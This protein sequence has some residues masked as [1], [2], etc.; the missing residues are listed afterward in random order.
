MLYRRAR[1]VAAVADSFVDILERRGIPRRKTFVV[2]NGVDLQRFRP[3][4]DGSEIK[5]QFSLEG[6]FIVMYIG[7]IGMAHALEVAL[8]AAR[9]TRQD[10]SIVYML[11]GTGARHDELENRAKELGLSNVVFA[12]RRPR[13]EVPEFLAAADAVLV[14]L[15]AAELFGNVIP[16]K[17]FEIMGCAKPIIMGVRGE[18]LRIVQDAGAALAMK[19]ESADDLVAAVRQLRDTPSLA[20]RLGRSGRAYVEAN[21]DRDKLAEDYIRLL[22]RAVLS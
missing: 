14:H 7:T 20:E 22:E 21:F 10:N 12:G 9:R 13:E 6:K 19:P 16:S 11:V 15:K 18:A 2:K 5:A 3:D 4:I 17:I 8:E 1:R